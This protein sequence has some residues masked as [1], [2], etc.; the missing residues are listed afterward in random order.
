MRLSPQAAVL[1]A[2]CIPIRSKV[3]G[4]GREIVPKMN[5]EIKGKWLTALRSGDYVQGKGLLCRVKKDGSKTYCCLGV[6]T[7]LYIQEKGLEWE[8][9]VSFLHFDDEDAILP[10]PVGNWSGVSGTGLFRNEEGEI[11]ELASVND[12]SDNFDKVIQIIEEKF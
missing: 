7:D 1:F 6:L 2:L 3:R 12:T 10:L 8:H 11:E 5:P 9:G 4:E